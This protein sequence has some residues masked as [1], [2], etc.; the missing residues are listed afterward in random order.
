[1]GPLITESIS[2]PINTRD[3]RKLQRAHSCEE[4]F[5]YAGAGNGES[6]TRITMMMAHIH[7]EVKGTGTRTF[8]LPT[9]AHPNTGHRTTPEQKEQHTVADESTL[10]TIP[11]GPGSLYTS[12]SFLILGALIDSEWLANTNSRSKDGEDHTTAPSTWHPGPPDFTIRKVKT[13]DECAYKPARIAK[14]CDTSSLLRIHRRVSWKL[15]SNTRV[16]T[17][18]RWIWITAAD[19]IYADPT[20]YTFKKTDSAS[21]WTPASVI[22]HFHTTSCRATV[23]EGGTHHLNGENIRNT[24]ARL[25]RDHSQTTAQLLEELLNSDD[26]EAEF[27][28]NTSFKAFAPRV[29]TAP[30]TSTTEATQ[31]PAAEPTGVK[32]IHVRGAGA[33]DTG[34]PSSFCVI[35]DIRRDGDG[36]RTRTDHDPDESMKNTDPVVMTV[37]ERTNQATRLALLSAP[38]N[39][40][41]P[42]LREKHA[43]DLVDCR[44]TRPGWSATFSREGAGFVYHAPDDRGRN[45]HLRDDL[46]AILSTLL[47]LEVLKEAILS[48]FSTSLRT[49]TG[50]LSAP[51]EERGPNIASHRETAMDL[52]QRFLAY[53]T[54]YW[55]TSVTSG[56]FF[57]EC[58]STFRTAR[59]LDKSAMYEETEANLERLTHLLDLESKRLED[60]A[61]EQDRRQEV[62]MTT[63][64]S[65]IATLFL[66]ISLMPSI[67][68]WYYPND[69]PTNLPMRWLWLLIGSLTMLFV[70][71]VLMRLGPRLQRFPHLLRIA[72]LFL[73]PRIELE[74]TRPTTAHEEDERAS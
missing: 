28:L 69:S 32:R 70:L 15:A 16:L 33:T 55:S 35:T 5:T 9:I 71:N 36:P 74:E 18:D 31:E 37:Q 17:P 7:E 45:A 23:H 2:T 10:P 6:T 46:S 27:V 14:H 52:W 60:T 49:L 54:E 57:E 4:A 67:L 61:R 59:H 65:L 51:P 11:D 44:Y 62:R 63:R 22:L 26:A 53:S 64:F 73:P 47:G 30:S 34:G 12:G 3:E 21:P 66:P 8:I 42:E 19:I 72:N 50:K 24:L 56:R 41:V 1:M 13:R 29:N 20:K 68:E 58:L 43:D 25:L 48:E 39:T 40:T 38:L